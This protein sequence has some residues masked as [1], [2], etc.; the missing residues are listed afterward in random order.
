GRRAGARDRVGTAATGFPSPA[1]HVTRVVS[2]DL[3]ALAVGAGV[4]TRFRTLGRPNVSP[5]PEWPGPVPSRCPPLAARN[6][7]GDP[8]HPT[9]QLWRERNRVSP[10]CRAHDVLGPGR[11]RTAG[12]AG[13]PGAATHRLSRRH[14]ASAHLPC[15]DDVAGIAGTT[16][17]AY[18]EYLLAAPSGHHHRAARTPSRA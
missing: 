12:A 15:R 1:G 6:P 14:D 9:P 5:A 17:P 7:A 16:A 2:P 11:Q 3:R 4:G 13:Q 10:L 18:L 8:A